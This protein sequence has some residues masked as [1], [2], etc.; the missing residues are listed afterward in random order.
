MDEN[1]K[2]KDENLVRSCEFYLSRL[3]ERCHGF[4]PPQQQMKVQLLTAK[5]P[6]SRNDL[7]ALR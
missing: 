2:S 5:N 3:I 1:K 7:T 6:G 4:P